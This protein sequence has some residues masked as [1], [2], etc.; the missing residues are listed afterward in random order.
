MTSVTPKP[1][2]VVALPPDCAAGTAWHTWD[3]TD[4]AS[5]KFRAIHGRTFGDKFLV[6]VVAIQFDDGAVRHA[7][8][9]IR[10]IFHDAAPGCIDAA[11]ATRLAANLLE[12]ANEI[13]RLN[14][15][16]GE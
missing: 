13:D 9:G 2:P 4:A 5:P 10:S 14:R 6:Q 16:T 3:S 15:W 7:S 8:I 11:D 12:A 1:E